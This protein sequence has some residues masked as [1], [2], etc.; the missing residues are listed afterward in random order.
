M[1]DKKKEQEG[2]KVPLYCIVGQRP[3]KSIKGANGGVGIY[4]L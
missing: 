2:L 4:A 1:P 3:V